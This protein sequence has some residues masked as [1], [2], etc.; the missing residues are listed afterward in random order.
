[1]AD[2]MFVWL[3]SGRTGRS[4]VGWRGRWL[5]QATRA[6]LPVP[7]GAIILDAFYRL[8]CQ[9]GMVE[10]QNGRLHISDPLYLSNALYYGV[11]LPR[12]NRLVTVSSLFSRQDDPQ[13]SQPGQSVQVV[14]HVEANDPHQF[15]QAFGRVWSAAISFDDGWRRDTLVMEMVQPIAN[16]PSTCGTALTHAL[17]AS[18]LVTYAVA[19][20]YA[21]AHSI[22]D[23]EAE[24]Q[25]QLSLPRLSGWQRPDARFLPFARRLQQL[26]RGVRR[27][28]RPGNWKIEW[29]DDGQVCWL[30]AICP[31]EAI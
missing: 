30:L 27:T 2:A 21:V 7:N 20:R 11:R 17:E 10:A 23:M 14:P 9:E 22:T 25:V 19:H 3:G 1:M 16:M 12:F 13:G 28:F 26:L 6:N 5:D 24:A 15:A 18:D 29:I 31:S 8:A 4:G